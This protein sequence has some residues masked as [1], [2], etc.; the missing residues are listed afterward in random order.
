VPTTY[1]VFVSTP[2]FPSYAT[3][4]TA[5]GAYK[6]VLSYAGANRP[7]LDDHDARV[8][9]ETLNG[10]FTYTGT[11][12]YGGYPGLPNSENAV[13][14][15][16]NYPEDTR[17]PGWDSDADGLPDWWEEVHGTDPRS[18]AGSFADTNADPEGDG[19]TRMDDFLAWLALPRVQTHSSTPADVDL[20]T[21]TVGFTSSP[22]RTVTLAPAS[23]GSG[24]LS[25]LPDGKTARFTPAPGFSGIARFSH[26]VTDSQGDSWSSEVGVRITAAKQAPVASLMRRNGN[27]EFDF[28]GIEGKTY[29]LEHSTNLTTWTL[30]S[31]IVASGAVQ[32]VVLPPQLE[33]ETVR[34][35]RFAR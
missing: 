8:I 24:T 4:R 33:P 11:G 5:R 31:S 18:P 30:S 7:R 3:E 29:Q 10:T 1:P 19:Y 12:P 16:E 9:Q 25:L 13:G 27:L 26:S 17:P 14:G 28:T 35:F 6:V 32:R 22:V 15:W 2:F 20:S 34:F 21:L 23:I